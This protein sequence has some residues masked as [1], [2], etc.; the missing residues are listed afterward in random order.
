MT[1]LIVLLVI[2]VLVLLSG[3]PYKI[4]DKDK[5]DSF[6]YN[7]YKTQVRYVPM[8][9]WFELAN[10]RLDDIDLKTVEVLGRK[11]IKDKDAVYFQDTKI[12]NADPHSFVAIDNFYAKDKNR[13]YYCS[14]S[15]QDIDINTFEFL[16]DD[17]IVLKDKNHS[18]SICFG[19]YGLYSAKNTVIPF[20]PEGIVFMSRQYAKDNTL[21]YYNGRTIKDADTKTFV[22]IYDGYARDC[23]NVYHNGEILTGADSQSFVCMG[24]Y[25]KD[26]YKVYYWGKE[27]KGIDVSSFVVLDRTLYTK[28]VYGVYYNVKGV[29]DSAG[30]VIYYTA[31]KVEGADSLTF[32][33][34]KNP[35][36]QVDAND[37]YRK[38]VRGKALNK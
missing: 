36:I 18:Y 35:T 11:F 38:Y 29:Y 1:V 28:D 16:E 14:H 31:I 21:V 24:E 30:F 3:H 4:I 19:D 5:S 2:V 32:E 34:I 9:N 12:I 33:L 20:L 23:N 27:L 7:F 15:F 10:K 13:V 25:A 17:Y 8:G 22:F 26:V 6:Y 37:K